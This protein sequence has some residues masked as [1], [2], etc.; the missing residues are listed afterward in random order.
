MWVS[1]VPIGFDERRRGLA[2]VMCI[3]SYEGVIVSRAMSRNWRECTEEN[4]E[5]HQ[6]VCPMTLQRFKPGGYRIQ[7]VHSPR[8][9]HVPVVREEYTGCFRTGWSWG[10][11][12][13]KAETWWSLFPAKTIR[14]RDA[15]N[16]V[17]VVRL[18]VI[19]FLAN[20]PNAT[21]NE[22]PLLVLELLHTNRWRGRHGEANG[23]FSPQFFVS[24]ALQIYLCW[25]EVEF[26]Y[27]A[28]GLSGDHVCSACVLN[29]FIFFGMSR[30]LPL[31]QLRLPAHTFRFLVFRYGRR[32]ILIWI[33]KKCDGGVMDSIDLTQGM[34]RWRALLIR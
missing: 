19:K 9:Q 34:D 1:W 8:H 30:C 18:Y 4:N 21:F 7:V 23:P 32:I 20:F 28:D 5:V 31:S 13:N 15:R 3:P 29:I 11:C 10:D 14:N 26:A 33:F 24:N 25:V 6:S 27:R 17:F 22:N 2:R 16:V 12:L